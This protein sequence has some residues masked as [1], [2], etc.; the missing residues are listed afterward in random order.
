LKIDLQSNGA[1]FPFPDSLGKQKNATMLQIHRNGSYLVSSGDNVPVIWNLKSLKMLND[2][3]CHLNP[4]TN[5]LFLVQSSIILTTS[6][7]ESGFTIFFWDSITKGL[8]HRMNIS[9]KLGCIGTTSD[10]R[11]LFYGCG[12]GSAH[13]IDIRS[14]KAMLKFSGHYSMVKAMKVIPDS[15]LGITWET[16]GVLKGWK[17]DKSQRERW[18]IEGINDVA[19]ISISENYVIVIAHT[20][21]FSIWIV[22][23]N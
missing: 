12:D 19:G 9:L 20:Q 7:S 17:M 4:I 21:R 11:L 22:G 14:K 10:E 5:L 2:F 16:N 6:D 15:S 23:N 1:I 8:M 18:K 3:C 13:I